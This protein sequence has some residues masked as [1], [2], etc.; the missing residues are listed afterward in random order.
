M[1]GKKSNKQMSQR[2]TRDD[3]IAPKVRKGKTG[4]GAVDAESFIEQA[5]IAD[6]Y[7]REA[8][9]LA[10][11]RSRSEAIRMIALKM[12]DDHMTS[13]HQL[14]STLRSMKAAPT[15]PKDLD[16]RRQTMIDNLDEADDDEFDQR[17]LEQQCTAHEEAV[18]LFESFATRGENDPG[19][20]MFAAG[21]LPSLRRHLYMVMEMQQG[22]TKA[23]R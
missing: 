9:R 14:K 16:K 3:D 22:M 2:Q 11:E 23:Q 18:A 5:A 17:Y 19:L 21:T 7:E 6:L 8:A 12:L 20:T 1:S 4:K 10:L 15:P 13:T